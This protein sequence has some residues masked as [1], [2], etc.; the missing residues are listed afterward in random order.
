MANHHCSNIILCSLVKSK[1][2]LISSCNHSLPICMHYNVL[3]T[4]LIL[5]FTYNSGRS[6]SQPGRGGGVEGRVGEGTGEV[7]HPIGGGSG[8]PTR[9]NVE[10]MKQNGTIWSANQ[11][12]VTHSIFAVSPVKLLKIYI[13]YCQEIPL[14]LLHCQWWMDQEEGTVNQSRCKTVV[15]VCEGISL[16]IKRVRPHP[17]NLAERVS[18]FFSDILNFLGP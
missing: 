5:I 15:G 3:F 11:A 7:S 9:E 1:N 8:G 13:I 18:F 2:V 6:R 10:K 17:P 12:F 14:I 16:Y 4:Y